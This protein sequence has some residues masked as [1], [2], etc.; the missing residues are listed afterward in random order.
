MS[1][2]WKLFI[3]YV[4]IMGIALLV[5]AFS[6]AYAAPANFTQ[7]MNMMDMESMW[8]SGSS[9]MMM[10]DMAGDE[11]AWNGWNNGMMSQQ[12]QTAGTTYQ[13]INAEINA[14]FRQS[15]NKALLQAGI[16]TTLAAVLVS[17][18]VSSRL[19][20]PIR[21]MVGISQRIARGRYQ[22]RL[23]VY[24]ND[25]LGELT[26]SFNQ[27]AATLAETETLRQ[28]LIADVSHE[29]KTPLATIKGYMEGLQDGIVP[30]TPEIYQ[31]VHREAD[32]LQRLVQDL[33][34]LS[35]A[36]AGQVQFQMQSCHPEEL[37]QS[38]VN[39]LQPQYVEK[40]ITLKKELPPHLPQVRADLD[41]GIQ[42]LV[43]LMGNALQ[44]TPIGG[45]VIVQVTPQDGQVRFSVKDTG[46]GLA[47]ADLERVFQRFYRVDK[48]R[49]RASGGN[50]IGL[51]IAR[52]LI[53]AQGGNIWAE[54]PG[55]GQGSTFSF[56]LPL[57]S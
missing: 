53:E 43:N 36:E 13:E 33:Q 25:E 40:N 8:M 39:R 9:G 26:L 24:E 44:Y 3:S 22:E 52:Q 47:P 27:M 29:L 56:T 5:L 34:E 51:T 31:M 12:N 35:R 18:L 6:T 16:A 11:N 30:A 14:H 20:K 48:S 10:E 41:R 28:Q 37:I 23:V 15:V 38:A 7:Q 57:A 46:V 4:A 1:L 45:Q 50:G 54:S 2:R 17:W 32:R 49:S 19:T 55:L 21:A 42:V